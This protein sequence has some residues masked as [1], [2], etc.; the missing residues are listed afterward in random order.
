[1]HCERPLI[2]LEAH[3]Q[4]FFVLYRDG[5]TDLELFEIPRLRSHDEIRGP[6]VG[7]FQRDCSRRHIDLDDLGGEF[8]RAGR[9]RLSG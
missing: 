8:R 7:G 4:G 9:C 5:I 2:L 6:A 1:M 3:G